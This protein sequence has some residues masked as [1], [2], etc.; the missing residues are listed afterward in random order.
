M[1]QRTYPGTNPRTLYDHGKLMM[2]KH[3]YSENS[4]AAVYGAG[5]DS[6]ELAA[7]FAV[8]ETEWSRY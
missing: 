5:E 8:N 6:H 3:M 1:E 7:V 4:K 2:A